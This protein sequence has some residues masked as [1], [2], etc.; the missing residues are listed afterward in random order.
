MACNC[1]SNEKK[2]DLA[3]VRKLAN[4]WSNLQESDVNIIKYYQHGIGYA[5]DFEESWINSGKEVVELIKFQ[6][7]KSTDV[8]SDT[9]NIEPIIA[10]SGRK[11][12]TTRKPVQKVQES[13]N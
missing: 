11:T 10:D 6:Q 4:A 1:I 3:Y 5:Y 12:P 13:R 2:T 9:A 7:H 8:L